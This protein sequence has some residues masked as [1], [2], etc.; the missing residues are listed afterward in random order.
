MSCMFDGC[1]SLNSLPNISNWNTT[2]VTDMNGM[3]A[4]CLKLKNIP[5]KFKK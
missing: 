5:S 4:R 1:Y 2:N 3:F